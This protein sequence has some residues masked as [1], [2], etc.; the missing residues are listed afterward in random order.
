MQIFSHKL[1]IHLLYKWT[2]HYVNRELNAKTNLFF[3]EITGII[4]DN[5]DLFLNL[6]QITSIEKSNVKMKKIL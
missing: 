5:S 6:S 4:V 2:L 3:F 1:E